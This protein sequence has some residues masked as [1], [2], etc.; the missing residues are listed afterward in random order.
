MAN[1]TKIDNPTQN[2]F[3]G[4]LQ[5]SLYSILSG[6][7]GGLSTALFLHLLQ[8]ATQTRNAAPWLLLGLPVIGMLIVW[9]YK[10]YGQ[11]SHRGNSLILDEIH[12][13]NTNIPLMMTP[14]IFFSTLATH[15]FGGSAGREG[16]SVQM[17]AS[18]SAAIGE[19]LH[20]SADTRKLLLMT[21]SA[22]GFGAAIGT[23][24]AGMIFGMEVLYKRGLRLSAWYPCLIASFVANAI[25]HSLHV[26]HTL[27]LLPEIPRIGFHTIGVILVAGVCFGLLARLFISTTHTISNTL[28]QTLLAPVLGGSSVLAIYALLDSTRYAGLGLSVIQ[29]AFKAP[30]T[31]WDPFYKLILTSLT[32]GSGFKGGEFTPLVFIGSTFGSA[33]APLL[34]TPHSFLAA[35]GFASVFAAAANTPL[36]CAIMAAEIFGWALLPYVLLSSYIAYWISGSHGIYPGQR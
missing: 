14:L 26:P 22:A 15:L 20:V 11:E 29:D 24:I 25:C 5:N 9:T 33:L 12:N 18:L 21:G 19:K 3:V 36:A 10:R 28:R 32:L 16:S 30:L 6:T 23:P 8:L 27:Y 35:L 2:R 13:P 1:Q 34:D 4:Y 31:F 7:V 17:G